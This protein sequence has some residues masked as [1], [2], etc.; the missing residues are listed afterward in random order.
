VFYYVIQWFAD[1]RFVAAE[2]EEEGRHERD[3]VP[4]HAEANGQVG[5][6]E[7]VGTVK[8]VHRADGTTELVLVV[9]DGEDASMILSALG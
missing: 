8:S 3:G 9:R 1:R 2:G 6:H 4:T 7:V 5:R